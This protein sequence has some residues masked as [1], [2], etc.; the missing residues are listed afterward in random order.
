[1]GKSE[2]CLEG[3]EKH[4][5][6]NTIFVGKTTRQAIEDGRGDLTP[7]YF[8]EYPSLF[9]NNPPDVAFIQV[10]APDE[11]GYCSYG[12]SVDYTK[13]ATECSKIVIAQI[14]KN[15]P[16]TPGDAFIHVSDIN[17][18]VEADTP[19]IELPPAKIGEVEKK[20][21]ENCA[22]LINDGQQTSL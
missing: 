14:N 19:I 11:H 13:P 10:S 7:C 18:I 21:G 17:Y 5:R 6:H 2:Y 12:V 9:R 22:S 15:M 20:I 16:R 8:S 4:F 3:M 1:M